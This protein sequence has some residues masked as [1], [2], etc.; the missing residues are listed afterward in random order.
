MGLPIAV[1]GLHHLLVGPAADG[2]EP[3]LAGD[4]LVR[5]IEDGPGLRTAQA[6]APEVRLGKL[7]Q[8]GFSRNEKPERELDRGHVIHEVE[9]RD[10]A[11]GLE[12]ERTRG[13]VL[14]PHPLDELCRLV[15]DLPALLG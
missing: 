12:D 15:L 9:F 1:E 8:L 6:R 3:E 7:Q 13:R 5:Q 11:V 2:A 14:F 10:V 4:G